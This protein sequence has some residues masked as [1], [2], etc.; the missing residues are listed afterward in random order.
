MEPFKINKI[1]NNCVHISQ[2]RHNASVKL[3]NNR[4]PYELSSIPLPGNYIDYMNLAFSSMSNNTIDKIAY[5][6]RRLNYK[7]LKDLAKGIGY[8]DFCLARRGLK[9]FTFYNLAINME[10][11]HVY[12]D[13]SDSIK[14]YIESGNTIENIFLNIDSHLK[15]DRT[16][17][18][19]SLLEENFNNFMSTL[20]VSTKKMEDITLCQ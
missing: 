4:D 16:K 2:S 1:T 5:F 10:K 7:K 19:T 11:I 12:I 18:L 15:I 8:S 9:Y 13:K 14:E 20:I 3:E 17:T 6:N